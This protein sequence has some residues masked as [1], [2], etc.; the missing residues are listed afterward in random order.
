[1]QVVNLN[2]TSENRRRI[3]YSG[4]RRTLSGETR[5]GFRDLTG[6]RTFVRRMHDLTGVTQGRGKALI[7]NRLQ[8]IIEGVNLKGAYG[9][10]IKSCDKDHVRHHLRSHA[11]QD[12]EAGELWHLNVQKDQVWRQEIDGLNGLESVL[13]FADNLDFLGA[14]E[15]DPQAAARDLLVIH[16]QSSDR[17]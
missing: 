3:L 16:Q 10:L 4:G 17:H 13:A 12:V 11:A 1:M 14:F 9:V 15:S 2:D 5:N 6:I 7:V 8:K